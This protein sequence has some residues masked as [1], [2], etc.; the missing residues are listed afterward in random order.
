MT[1]LKE[2]QDNNWVD[3]QTRLVIIDFVVYNAYSQVFA[4]AS[5]IAKFEANGLIKTK[6][7]LNNVLRLYYKTSL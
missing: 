4:T 7:D 1:H 6:V 5:L 2:L 3:D